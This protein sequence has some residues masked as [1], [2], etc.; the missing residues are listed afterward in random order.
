MTVKSV[1]FE[2]LTAK[3]VGELEK[4]AQVTWNDHIIGKRSGIRRQIDV[5]IRRFDPDFLG[6]LDAKDYKRPATIERIDALTGVMGDVEANYGALVCSGGFAKSIHRY[7]RACGISLLNI[8]DAQSLNWS[9]ELKIPIIWTELTPLVRVVG[10]AAF[11]VG[12]SFITDDPRGLQVTTDG[13][14]TIANP[15]ST[16][17]RYWNRSDADRRIDVPHMLT[18]NQQVEAFVVD[19]GGSPRLRPVGRYGI[20]YVVESHTWLGKFEPDECRGV[21]DYLD[22]QA[23]IASHLPESAIPVRRDDSWESI[24]DPSKFALKPQGTIVVCQQPV[25]L[26][27]AKVEALDVKFLGPHD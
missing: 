7:A 21:V 11:E 23:F 19:V 10:V 17:E 8:H 5:S 25:L 18:F 13:G 1:E 22:G 14:V 15:L 27:D 9:L 16:F 3:I 12:D 26:S 2:Q 4:T 6:V 20:E 24:E